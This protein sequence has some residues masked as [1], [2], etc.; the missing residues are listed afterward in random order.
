MNDAQGYPLTTSSPQAALLYNIAQQNLLEYR[1][2]TM[3]SI[4]DAIEA[5]PHFAMAHCLRGYQFMMYGS[6]SVL[7]NAKSALRA[8]EAGA[9]G[10]TERE[11]MH[12]EALRAWT[13][14]RTGR[15]ITT[16]EQLLGAYPLDIVA[17]RM[18]HFNCFWTGRQHSLRGGAA[19]VLDRWS[20]DMPGYGNVLG[21]LAFGYEECGQY[22][23]AEKF[24]RLAVQ[25]NPHDLWALHAVAHVM[26]MEDRQR[27]GIDWLTRPED[28]WSDRNPFKGHLWWHLALFHLESGHY[29]QVLDLYDRC[30]RNDGSTFYLDIQNAAS[31]LAR[32]E[33]LGV[34]AGDR[35]TQLA[36]FAEK[37]IGDH[38]LIFTDL[39]Y[40]MALAKERRFD[41]AERLLAS[42]E[43]F[44]A[45]DAADSA[46]VVRS[47]GLPLCRGILRFE[48]GDYA[49]AVDALA[50]LHNNDAPIGASHA[51]R[52]IIDQYL[53]EATRRASN[54]PRTRMLLAERAAL[55]PR[56]KA[57][58]ERHIDVTR[59][60]YKTA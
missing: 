18:H 53:I 43:E 51:Q 44:A 45:E 32:L 50:P 39:H 7:N 28:H 27:E 12:V 14:G 5:D 37:S 38:G 54:L 60:I 1:L 31:L 33:L 16:W 3:Q 24:G 26:E 48:Q 56:N 2:V 30:V 4:K 59:R 58:V 42:M 49:G 23:E 57:A 20:Q 22:R 10:A 6:F 8:A 25:H 34:E 21:M 15:A 41:A 36:D 40:M 11:R 35:W 52:D 19:A 13:E 29:D 17:L 47:I 46:A 9:A 55:R